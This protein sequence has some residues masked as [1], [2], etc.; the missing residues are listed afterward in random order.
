MRAVRELGSTLRE[1]RVGGG[2]SLVRVRMKM[3]GR[4]RGDRVVWCRCGRSGFGKGGRARRC[5]RRGASGTWTLC[6]R[7]S[8]SQFSYTSAV[9]KDS[10]V[11]EYYNDPFCTK[12]VWLKTK[13]PNTRRRPLRRGSTFILGSRNGFVPPPSLIF[14]PLSCISSGSLA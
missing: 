9:D 7:N 5:G 2:C 13:F 4:R 1:R 6:G 11:A 12:R 14:Q 3:R 8:Q 10:L